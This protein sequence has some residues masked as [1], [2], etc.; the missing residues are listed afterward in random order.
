M[1]EETKKIYGHFELFKRTIENGT[2]K[3]SYTSLEKYQKSPYL[4]STNYL[5]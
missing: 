1:K 2:L 5:F 3:K 4:Q